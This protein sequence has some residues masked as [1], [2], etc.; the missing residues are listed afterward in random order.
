MARF[1]AGGID[2]LRQALEKEGERVQRNG[3]AAVQAGARV[4]KEAMQQ[5]V[6]VRTGELQKHIKAGQTKYSP[7]DGYYADVAPSGKTREGERYATIGFVLE[8]GRSNM[9]AQPWMRP[10]VERSGKAVAAAMKAE[11]YKD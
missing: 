5:T 1:D 3:A 6:P 9:P 8:Y 10:A 7:G 11:L 4:L 2:R